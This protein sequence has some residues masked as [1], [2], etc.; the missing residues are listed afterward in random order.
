MSILKVSNPLN[1]SRMRIM[2]EDIRLMRIKVA[3]RADG[4][5]LQRF[6]QFLAQ[7]VLLGETVRLEFIPPGYNIQSHAQQSG[8]GCIEYAEHDHTE[9]EGWVLATQRLR[10]MHIT[11]LRSA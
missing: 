11:R 3:E 2:E 8:D 7:T 9:M 1:K 4:E 10:Q 6:A 5:F